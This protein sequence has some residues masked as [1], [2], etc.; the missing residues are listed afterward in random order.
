MGAFAAMPR[1]N[2]SG[3]GQILASGNVA[4]ASKKVAGIK[5]DIGSRDALAYL[6]GI[7]EIIKAAGY[8]GLVVVIDEAE[9]ILRMRT[10]SRG[11]SLNGIR[12][13]ADDAGRFPG[14]VWLFTGTPEFFDSRRGVAGLAPLDERIRFLKSGAF[15]S[16]RQAQLELAPFDAGRLLAVAF[17]LREIYPTTQRRRLEDKIDE[18]F[19]QRLVADCTAGFKG[20]VGVVPR[21]FLRAF[22]DELDLVEEHD[23]Y[24]PRK[25]VFQAAPMTPEEA[26]AATGA[27]PVVD[28]G[29]AEAIP[30]EDVW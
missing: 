30:A 10:D 18:R 21:Q 28:G 26:A 9:T 6:R 2:V 24:D 19:V 5:G 29:E 15:A 13:I 1:A 8:A 14:L 12:Q 27:T 3:S 16:L 23:D 7:L 22:V 25:K 17:K 4:Q 11:K 20:D